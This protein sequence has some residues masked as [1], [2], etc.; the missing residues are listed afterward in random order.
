MSD[1]PIDWQLVN[2]E[3]AAPGVSLAPAARPAQ[4]AGKTVGLAWNGKP[5]GDHA[6]EEIAA[7][8]NEH[9]QDVRYIK[10][11]QTVPETVSPREL[12]GEVIQAM[13]AAKPDVV[14]VSQGD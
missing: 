4:L 1:A 13:A 5:G 9:V 10:F 3:G 2:P 11:W 14:I 12:R 7:L 8:L 6:L